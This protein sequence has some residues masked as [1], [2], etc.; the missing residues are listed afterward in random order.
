M[1]LVSAVRAHCFLFLFSRFMHA[2]QETK[3]EACRKALAQL[4]AFFGVANILDEQ[5]AGVGPV[6]GP[7][8][9][10]HARHAMAELLDDLRPNAIAFVDAF[11]IPDRVLNS[12]L[13]RY[14]GNVY[15]ALFQAALRS[16]LNQTDPFLGYAEVLRPRLDLEALARGNVPIK[17]D[18]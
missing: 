5:W 6:F 1:Q 15:E 2:V 11:D 16:S 18:L 13:G 3:D 8:Q 14:D 7:A 10:R 9:L 4:A 17:S 12:T